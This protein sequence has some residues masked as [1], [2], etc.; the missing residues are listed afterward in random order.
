MLDVRDAP[1]SLACLPLG[2]AP[3]LTRAAN[4]LRERGHEIVAVVTA[5]P[6]IRRW[7]EEAGIRALTRHEYAELLEQRPVDVLLS[8]TYPWIIPPEL[9]R[10][11]RVAAINYHDGPLPRYAGMNASAWALANGEKK[12]AVVW[13][14]LASDLDAGD[15]LERREVELDARETSLSLNMKNAVLALDSFRAIL[16]RLERSELAGTPQDPNVERQLFS[17][18]DRPAALCTLDLAEPA[19]V[20]DRLIRACEFG[21]FPNRFG[22]VKL[23][24]GDRAVIVREAHRVEGGTERVQAGRI[25]RVDEDA[26]EVDCGSGGLRLKRFTTLYGAELSPLQAASALG[27][28]SG[29]L[30]ADPGRSARRTISRAVAEAEPF[31]V[32]AL[33]SALPLALPFEGGARARPLALPVEVPEKLRARFGV[34]TADAWITAFALVLSALCRQEAFDFALVDAGAREKLGASEPLFFPAVP[35]RAALDFETSFTDARQA[36]SVARAHVTER[37]AF[38]KDLIARHPG[39]AAQPALVCGEL[40]AVAILLGRAEA[41]PGTSLSLVLDGDTVELRTNGRIAE[42]RLAALARELACVARAAAEDPEVA[43]H[44][45]DLLDPAELFRQVFAWN[46]TLRKFPDSLCIHDL[47]ERQAE[48]RPDAIALVFEGESRTFHEVEAGANRVANALIR[49]GIKPGDKVG[50]L[51]DRGF[52]LVLALLGVVKAGAAYVPFDVAYPKER[53]DFMLLDAACALLLTSRERVADFQPG[54]ALAADAPEITASPSDRPACPARATDVCYV[55]YTSGSTGQPKGVVL[56]HRAVVNTLDWVNRTFEV[57]PEDRLLFVTSPSFDLSVYDVF[58]ALG[59]GASVEI[60]SAS[61]LADPA[62][63]VERLC[64]PGITIWDS[65]PA[66]LARLVPFLPERAPGSTLRRVM[67]SGDWIPLALPP[68]LQRTFSGVL[69]ESLG[70]ATEAAIWSNHHAVRALDP[71]WVSVPYGRPIQ[72]AR[73]YVLDRRLRPVP[74]GVAGDLYIGGVCLAEGYLNRPELTLDRFIPDPFLPG[75]R[76][77]KTGDLARYFADG[78]IEF[79]GRADFQVKIRGFRVELG[80]VE[81]AIG[82]LPGVREAVCHTYSD[83]SGAKSLAA[84]VAPKPGAA[85]D[86]QAIKDALARALPEFMVPSQV[87]FLSALPMTPNGKIDRKALP[88]PSARA[89]TSAAVA[90]RSELERE[91]VAIWEELLERKPIGVT[92]D[93]FALGGHSLLAVMLVTALKTRLGIN[94]PLSR[95]LEQP[96]IAAFAAGI[97]GQGEPERR[98][99]H[100]L[101]LHA[102]GARPPLVLVAGVGGYTFTYRNFPKLLGKD[103]PVFTFMAVGAEDEGELVEHSIEHMAEIYEAELVQA[104]PTG[105]LVLGGFS[106][107]ALP[108]FELAR[109]LI[110]R[111]REVPLIVSFDGFA[112]GYPSVLPFSERVVAHAREFISR[113]GP[114]RYAYLRDRAERIQKRAYALLGLQEQLAPEIPFADPNM[115]ERMKKLW[116]HHMRARSRYSSR[117]RLPCDLLLVRAA[118]P[119]RWVAT[120]MD[121]PNYGWGPFVSGEIS[122]VTIPGEHTELFAPDNQALIA[123]AVSAHISRHLQPAQSSPP[124]IPVHDFVQPWRPVAGGETA[125]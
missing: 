115:S 37:G 34:A 26:L 55:I 91:L 95:V 10:K 76:V 31:F 64:A 41:P 110:A 46:A 57:T 86:E 5:A 121:D 100:L 44:A 87:L 27:V 63:L 65:A 125:R 107:G 66:A 25:R 1:G 98:S 70:G 117:A 123:Q 120:K 52:D 14:H 28:T 68:A 15:I 22:L 32:S 67:L 33:S 72:N 83:A 106:F 118:V 78:V 35:L 101:A 60:A 112:P 103:Q 18:H 13:H 89:V 2:D 93:F 11:A 119:Y 88:S 92:D 16:A 80:E 49:R 124:P 51:L 7:C 19:E 104:A 77:Y 75:E 8:I 61:L 54:L 113:D 23:V 17:R 29:A 39:L 71:S 43:L 97:E 12:H 102:E 81:H 59:A 84:Y 114:G 30:L 56:T 38:L 48:E 96:N 50:V 42:P 94:V 6:A 36:L 111:G 24:N 116:V 4:L 9:I 109:R 105:A 53:V 58:G 3:L 99:R 69:V 122:V 85:L 90:P 74:V 47:F 20:S 108:A 62:R 40:S 73:Y 79:L 45:I 21:Q 82:K